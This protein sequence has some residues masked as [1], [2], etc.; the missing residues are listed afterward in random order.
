METNSPTTTG[1]R[2]I[3]VL[4][5][6][7]ARRC[8]GKR[9]RASAVPLGIP[10]SSEIAVAVMETRSDSQVMPTISW[11]AVMSNHTACLMP[12]Q[13]R[14]TLVTLSRLGL[15]SIR[16]EQGLAV[17]L[18]AVGPDD[19]LCLRRHHKV[20][21]RLPT[22]RIDPWMAR[23]VDLHYVI[24]VQEWGIPGEQDLQVKTPLESQIGGPVGQRV[25]SLFRGNHQSGAHALS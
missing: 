22:R 14:S 3:P 2:P 5:R 24:D 11:S 18:D 7:M 19:G 6:L 21:E 25:G 20:R 9:L 12:A 17:L 16:E 10:R 23:R 15:T 4:I 8:P 1:G 13:I